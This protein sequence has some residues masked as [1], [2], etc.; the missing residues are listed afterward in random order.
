[1]INPCFFEKLGYFLSDEPTLCGG[2][3]RLSQ[4]VFLQINQILLRLTKYWLAYSLSASIGLP[5][6]GHSTDPWPK[7]SPKYLD[8]SYKGKNEVQLI[9]PIAL[10]TAKEF[11]RF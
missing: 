7:S 4:A 1:M 11:C 5:L 10:R 6:F 8:Q 3:N 2:S 9:N